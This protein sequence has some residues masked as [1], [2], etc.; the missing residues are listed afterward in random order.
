MSSAYEMQVPEQES[1]LVLTVGRS[2]HKKKLKRK[3]NIVPMSFLGTEFF[4]K[5]MS[6]SRYWGHKQ[7]LDGKS[8]M[9][10]LRLIEKT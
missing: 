6:N 7:A 10:G 1:S 9:E 8:A 3:W 2:P 4:N 5:Q